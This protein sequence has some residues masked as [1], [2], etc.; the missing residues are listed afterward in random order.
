MAAKKSKKK[1]KKAKAARKTKKAAPKKK[2]AKRK[3]P[4]ARRP[5][6]KTKK[7]AAK[8][9]KTKATPQAAPQA[10]ALPWREPLPGETKLGMVD[11]YYSHIGVLVLKLEAA[12]A[13]GDKIHVR[14]HTTDLT[15]TVDSMQIEHQMVSMAEAGAGVGI[16]A[17]QKCRKG[18]YVYKIG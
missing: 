1:Q 14:G 4:K 12:L 6:P 3:A 18:D 7:A 17:S 16:K 2:A 5:A 15:Q 10:P 8:A 11:D 9:P 13:V